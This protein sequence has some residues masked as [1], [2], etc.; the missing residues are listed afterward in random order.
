MELLAESQHSKASSN[1]EDKRRERKAIFGKYKRQE[2]P[3]P[4]E[5][6][7]DLLIA[8]DEIFKKKETRVG[9]FN[10]TPAKAK[11]EPPSPAKTDET[12][13]DSLVVV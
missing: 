7:K 10:K 6:K 9:D 2:E 4:Q 11:P 5:Y 12:G 3:Q 8:F 13:G 1:N